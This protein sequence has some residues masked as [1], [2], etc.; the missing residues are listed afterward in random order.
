[1]NDSPF[2]PPAPFA[3]GP[4]PP[5]A[6][7]RKK[8]QVKVMKQPRAKTRLVGEIKYVPPTAPT[9]DVY[10]MLLNMAGMTN[11][12]VIALLAVA[13]ALHPLNAQSRARVLGALGQK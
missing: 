10:S 9:L 6:K 8:R 13:K 12:E 7:V 11:A 2:D 3:P 4:P 1:M 5:V